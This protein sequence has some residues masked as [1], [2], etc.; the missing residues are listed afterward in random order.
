MLASASP[1]KRP[2]C[3]EM[4]EPGSDYCRRHR[5]GNGS[6]TINSAGVKAAGVVGRH[7]ADITRAAASCSILLNV[8]F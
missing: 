5:Y 2:G 6:S 4:A 8:C 7:G 1:C 3:N